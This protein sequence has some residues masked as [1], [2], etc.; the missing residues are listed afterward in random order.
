MGFMGLFYIFYYQTEM[1]ASM[2]PYFALHFAKINRVLC[3]FRSFIWSN[4][5]I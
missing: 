1:P 2:N 5:N 3:D 4:R